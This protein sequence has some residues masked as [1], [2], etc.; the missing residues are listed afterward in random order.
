MHKIIS[1]RKITVSLVT[2]LSL[3]ISSCS[4]KTENTIVVID[5]ETNYSSNEVSFGTYDNYF[6]PRIT[7]NKLVYSFPQP[8]SGYYKLIIKDYSTDVFIKPGDSIL[9]SSDFLNSE[10]KSFSGNGVL[11]SN[12]I[13]S[14]V[15]FSESIYKNIDFDSIYSLPPMEFI[16][17]IDSI[18]SL[19]NKRL[20]DFISS[21]KVKD[22]LFIQTEKN[23]ILYEASI[24][25]NRYYRDHKFLTGKKQT[26][27]DEFNSYLAKVNFNDI[28][29]M[30][31]DSYRE[32]LYTYF[33][34]I[35][36]QHKDRINQDT[37]F[38]EIAFK[39]AMNTI[40]EP[41]TKSYALYRIMD[42]HLN[43][44]PI[45]KLGKLIVDFNRNCNNEKY[46]ETINKYYSKLEKLKFGM[47]APNFSFP[48]IDERMVS[49]KDFKG[50]LVYIDIW[51]SYCSPCFKEFPMLQ[52]LMEKFDEQEIVFIGI[53]YDSD[54]ILWKKTMDEKNLKG[55][56]LFANGWNSQ[57]GKDYLVNSNPRFILI[58]KSGNFIDAKA[59]GPSGNIE[60]IINHYIKLRNK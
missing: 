6:T 21:E 41:A 47:P 9:V 38:T 18:F 3:V 33:E 2:L 12:Y 32:F 50:K 28:D 15:P 22:D 31:L 11:L 45:N 42:V 19:K 10:D 52:Q 14:D 20:A 44:T 29:I 43:E 37:L 4:Q 8:S 13:L 51:N 46:R 36:L 1:I 56:Q 27:N 59:P 58:D 57:F 48:D 5:I 25:K 60:E 53:S 34:S 17:S 23:R 55:I 40:K 39:Y 7:D 35:G 24:E 16:K 54:K 26:L 49:L 30:H